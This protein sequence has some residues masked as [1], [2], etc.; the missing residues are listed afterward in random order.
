MTR[1]EMDVRG[2]VSLVL[3]RRLGNSGT[4]VK[5]PSRD[6]RTYFL[7]SKKSLPRAGLDRAFAGSFKLV[8]RRPRLH[9]VR[10][11]SHPTYM[12]QQLDI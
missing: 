10:I 3:C 4:T 11:G 12:K 5:F 6:Y 8:S 1:I 2:L 9:G 7:L